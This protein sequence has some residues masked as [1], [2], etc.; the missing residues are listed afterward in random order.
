M[1]RPIELTAETL[2][3]DV[4]NRLRGALNDTT[5]T[6]W[7]SQA[8]GAEYGDDGFVVAVPNNFTREWIEGHFLGLLH[9]VVKDATG[10]ERAVRLRV[11]DSL[12]PAR[13]CPSSRRSRRLS[14]RPPRPYRPRRRPQPA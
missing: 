13:R 2:W 9:A 3:A 5:F 12:E 7:F 1:E 14:S 4:S 6:T 10:D 11:D 8:H